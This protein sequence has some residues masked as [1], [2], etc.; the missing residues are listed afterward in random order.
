MIFIYLFIR[1][2]DILKQQLTIQKIEAEKQHELDLLRL[3]FFTNISHEFR[4]PLTLIV[5]PI[6]QI[7]YNANQNNDHTN[8]LQA[9]IIKRNA[10]RLLKLINELLDFRKLDTNSEVLTLVQTDIST[11]VTDIYKSFEYQA[12]QKNIYFSFNQIKTNVS[13]GLDPDKIEKVL[14]NILSNAFKFTPENGKISLSINEISRYQEEKSDSLELKDGR[15]VKIEV[16][17]TGLGIPDEE[18]EKI[19]NPF[20][21][22]GKNMLKKVEGSGIGLS[23]TKQYVELHGGKIIAGN[24]SLYPNAAGFDKGS[25][26]TVYLPI[27]DQAE[28]G[29]S[30]TLN[31]I[32]KTKDELVQLTDNHIQK[33]TKKTEA[34]TYKED[35][36]IILVI[37]DNQD[38][39]DYVKS[40][41]IDE[42]SVL[43]ASDG[44]E[45]YA[46][47]VDEIPDLIICDVMMNAMSGI[48]L[49]KNIKTDQRTSHIPVILLTALSEDDHKIEGL[50]TGADD[51]LTKPFKTKVLIARIQNLILNRKQLQE[52]FSKG[53]SLHTKSVVTNTTDQLFLKKAIGIVELY[54]EDTEFD[55]DRFT[56]EIGMSRAQ[57]YR[58]IKA[59]SGQS[60]NEFVKT[61]RLK[62]AAELLIDGQTTVTEVAAKVG[63]SNLS[64]FTRSFSKQFNI[65]PSKYA[66][67]YSTKQ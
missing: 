59:I 67:V 30:K 11:L 16:S 21:Q 22:V 13:I 52:K 37:D 61:I 66:E 24:N 6:E 19:F 50:E 35:T 34:R 48:E 31:Y 23:I 4:T 38:M 63:F 18:K 65:N 42:F 20:Y 60:V 2:K 45:G 39:R 44:D 8:L 41:L 14:Y 58:K 46:I 43:V 7:L 57:L 47:A 12:I 51:F 49:C 64:F 32:I 10:S 5:G 27:I 17:D 3:K 56:R 40:E 62:K 29:F 1:S 55:T 28:S 54:I 15:Y 33:V 25:T 53:V 9:E 36:P 26:F